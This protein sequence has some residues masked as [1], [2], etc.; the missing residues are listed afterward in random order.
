MI[1]KEIYF[2][3]VVFGIPRVDFRI[4][5]FKHRLF[6]SQGVDDLGDH[7]GPPSL[8]VLGDALRL[9]HNHAILLKE[10]SERVHTAQNSFAYPM[11][12]GCVEA[13]RP[14]AHQGA[15]MLGFKRFFNARRV[16]AGVAEI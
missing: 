1:H 11:P 10:S 14:P 9:D 7:I 12:S 4:R 13:G 6:E 15:P 3:T 5:S 2:R 8:H 16:V